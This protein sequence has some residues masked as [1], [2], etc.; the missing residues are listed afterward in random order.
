MLDVL[1]S[2]SHNISSMLDVLKSQYHNISQECVA[3][4][5]KDMDKKFS[6][7]WNGIGRL[8]THSVE[9]LTTIIWIA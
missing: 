9:I 6:I 5:V 8:V 7:F 1:K 3:E 2:Q 4:D